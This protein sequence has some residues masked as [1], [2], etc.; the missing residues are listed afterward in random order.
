MDEKE[1]IKAVAAAPLLAVSFF[2]WAFFLNASGV[3]IKT[4]VALQD[5]EIFASSISSPAF[6]IF[7]V[8]FPISYALAIAFA[9]IFS[10]RFLQALCGTTFALCGFVFLFVF[11]N[12]GEYLVAG[13]FYLISL[14][15]VVEVALIK[16]EELKN[17]VWPRTALAA[18][19][20]GMTV[21][22]VGLFIST[23]LVVLPAQEELV[24]NF[25]EK[26]F[27]GLIPETI[28][29]DVSKETAQLIVQTQTE[30]VRQIIAAPAFQ[31]LEQKTDPDVNVFVTTMGI[32]FERVKSPEYRQE[33]ETNIKE[34]QLSQID[35]TK[36]R[37][38]LEKVKEKV[39]LFST[40]EEYFWLIAL[41]TVL[42]IFF[43]AS[44]VIVKPLGTLY[45]LMF[46]FIAEMAK[47]IG[48]QPPETP[49]RPPRPAVLPAMQSMQKTV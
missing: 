28:K 6:I 2:L 10:K 33:L 43:F 23:L 4:V 26:F 15:I 20:S 25:E 49:R 13:I 30:T 1:L 31:N 39:P 5:L 36:V 38:A 35:D 29:E 48:E 37:E 34:K 16:F 22:S 19:S 12:L 46:L 45:A 44:S 17:L 8:F 3:T 32:L 9:K 47:K 24:K 14:L 21:L 42:S 27:T 7:F 11:Q 18:I 40:F 41:L